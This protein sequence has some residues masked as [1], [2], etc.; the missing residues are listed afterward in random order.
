MTDHDERGGGEP[1][2]VVMGASW[3]GLDAVE[4]LLDHLPADFSCPV[5]LVQHRAPAPSQLTDLLRRHTRWRVT[6]TDDKARIEPSTLFVAPPGY[7]LLVEPGH[8][9]LSTEGPHRYSR[10]SIDVTFESAADAYAGACIGI[11]LTGANAD[12]A[13]GLARIAHRGGTAIVQDPGDAAEPTMPRAALAAV[14]G[15]LVRTVEGIAGELS[16]RCGARPG[17]TA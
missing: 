17:T 15:A 13:A 16:L 6:E 8:L 11:V 2:L 3:G 4:R 12:G 10:P 7:H 9:A 14:P 5:V 1:E